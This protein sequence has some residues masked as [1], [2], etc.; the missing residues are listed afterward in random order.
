[1]KIILSYTGFLRFE[2]RSSGD[3]L[4]VEQG[5]TITQVLE[6]LGIRP[7]HRRFV[8]AMVNGEKGRP[9]RVLNDGEELLLH[10]P[11]GGG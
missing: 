7:E 4:E 11:V 9:G 10:L 6:Q 5:C 3:A 8:L 2:N 1:M